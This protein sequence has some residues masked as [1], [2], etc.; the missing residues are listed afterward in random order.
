[1][2]AKQAT[3][4]DIDAFYRQKRFAVVGVS[5]NEKEYSRL[6][7]QELK[8]QGYDAVP[9]NPNAAEIEGAR[10]YG[11]VAEVAPAVEG[12]MV[13]LPAQAGL[14]AVRDCA[15]AGIKRVWLRYR[16]PGAE[17][18]CRQQGITLVAGYCPFM[19]VPGSN[20]FHQCHAFG[21]RLVGAYPS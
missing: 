8:K 13:L 5:R 7:F 10:C 14:D 4:A 1:V 18:L 19:F 2:R 11:S 3:R 20:F 17:E 21:L 16:V 6:V 15:Q 12:A 9:V